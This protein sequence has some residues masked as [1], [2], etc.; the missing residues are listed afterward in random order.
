MSLRPLY[1]E[2]PTPWQVRLDAGVAL[3]VSAP[4]RARM[5]VPLTR[6]SRV[7]SGSAAQWT[8]EALLGCLAAGV[9]VLFCDERNGVK[10]WC[11]GPRRR[12]TTLA[13]LIRIGLEKRDW[14][15]RY[16][17]WRR[18]N[19]AEEIRLAAK[20]LGL[21]RTAEEPRAARASMA[22]ALAKRLGHPAGPWLR[23]LRKPAAGVAA[24]ALHQIIGDP[25][26]CAY[27][28]PGLNLAFDLSELLEWRL[29]RALHCTP[30]RELDPASIGRCAAAIV[31]KRE[32]LLHRGCGEMLGDLEH[33]LR[34]WLL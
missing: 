9:P 21:P 24:A 32:A 7:V 6:L 16:T 10:G 30:T 26:L 22:N 34:E 3:A 1:L 33:L 18:R 25:A 17:E 29:Y 19:A 2:Q 13:E 27:A 14:D 20:D 5:L 11:F 12:E 4:E 8:T 23:A 28:R 31:E 15:D